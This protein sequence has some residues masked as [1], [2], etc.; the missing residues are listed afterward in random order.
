MMA[1]MRIELCGVGWWRDGIGGCM[2]SSQQNDN[3]SGQSVFA[4]QFKNFGRLDADSKAAAYAVELAL[5]DAGLAYP[6]EPITVAGIAGGSA[7]GCYEP[8]MLYF[9]DYVKCGRTLGRGNYFIYTLPTSP[10][11]ECAI[12]FGLNGPVFYTGAAT[13]SS[14]VATGSSNVATDGAVT[15]RTEDYSRQLVSA[16]EAAKRAMLD[17]QAEVMLAGGAM[18]GSAIFM[19]LRPGGTVN[20]DDIMAAL[21]DGKG[22][23]RSFD[24]TL[25]LI[26]EITKTRGTGS[27]I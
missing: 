10:L 6:L 16:L 27:A 7:L 3:A 8:D 17:S 26:D 2:L 1:G 19:A 25:R 23:A 15:D 21:L 9:Q 13:G 18:G 11:A 22:K 4:R 12:H 20:I 5:K 24:E 14:N